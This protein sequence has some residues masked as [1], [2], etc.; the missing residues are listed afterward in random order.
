MN[1]K[2]ILDQNRVLVLNRNWQ[3]IGEKTVAEA[4][5]MMAADAATARSEEHTSE[6]QS[7]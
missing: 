2:A 4:F 3:V 6:L 1:S 7:H 5:S